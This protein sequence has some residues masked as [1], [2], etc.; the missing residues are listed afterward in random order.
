M[1]NYAKEKFARDSNFIGV[2][3]FDCETSG[4]IPGV[5]GILDIAAINY[6]NYGNEQGRFQSY[7]NPG[8]D[9]EF[10][11]RAMEVN[12]IP[13]DKIK[14]SRHIREVLPE[15]IAFMKKYFI[16]DSRIDRDGKEWTTPRTIT[17]GHNLY[18]DINHV[19]FALGKYCPELLKDFEQVTRS[20]FCT[21]QASP[22]YEKQMTLFGLGKYYGISNRAPHTA[23]GDVEQTAGIY[24]QIRGW[25]RLA[26]RMF[27]MKIE[28]SKEKQKVVA[29]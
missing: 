18:F 8:N 29:E 23:I 15:F 20:K 12:Q 2:T 16:L 27:E 6:D 28:E 17:A 4:L 11:Q 13:M 3:V 7:V 5:H 21:Q 25:Q 22:V 19:N 1:I 14:N 10:D 24:F 9:I 26:E